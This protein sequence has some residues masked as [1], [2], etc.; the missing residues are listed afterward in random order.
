MK[1]AIVFLSMLFF[2]SSCF[3]LNDM[4]KGEDRSSFHKKMSDEVKI[5]LIEGLEQYKSKNGHYPISND[6]YFLSKFSEFV[7]IF[8]CN[9]YQDI[10]E[11][12]KIV[13]SK[14]ITGQSLKDTFNLYIGC[15]NP[16][17]RFDYVSLDGLTYK[18][19]YTVDK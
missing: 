13:S 7:E 8:P 11:N 6:K 16:S 12:G 9:L 1:K 17:Y 5:K 18:L 10:I 14:N 2:L 19:V 15:G 4:F 3:D